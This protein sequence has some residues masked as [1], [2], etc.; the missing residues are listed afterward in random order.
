MEVQEMVIQGMAVICAQGFAVCDQT[1]KTHEMNYN[2]I[3]HWLQA[4]PW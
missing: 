1:T 3:L 2:E 4:S